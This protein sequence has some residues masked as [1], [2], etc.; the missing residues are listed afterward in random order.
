MKQKVKVIYIAGSGRTGS[1]LLSAL[2]AQHPSC[3]NIGQS[4]D[5]SIAL[6][7]SSQCTCGKNITK[8]EYWSLVLEMIESA[9]TK[10]NISREPKLFKKLCNSISTFRGRNKPGSLKEIISLHTSYID[11]LG[12]KYTACSEIANDAV[13]VDSSKSPELVVALSQIPEIELKVINLVRYPGAVAVSWH[14]RNNDWQHTMKMCKAW[15]KRQ[16]QLR[17]F[18]RFADIPVKRIL[19][20]DF[21]SNPKTVLSEIQKWA[22]LIPNPDIFTGKNTVNMKWD[23]Q[24][25]FPPANEKFLSEKP[26][27][28][29]IY[30][31][32]E[33][34]SVRYMIIRWMA[35][36]LTF[37]ENIRQGYLPK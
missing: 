20:E 36:V 12:C 6:R 11:Y 4:R 22:G 31:H 29:Q 3:F 32:R 28:L 10:I 7:E 17:D 33:W 23:N 35:Y 19:Y 34:M 14:K 27:S 16:E 30:D 25:L 13:L 8:C 26:V 18:T 37:P 9:S 21:V 2:I 15:K 24:H 5:V 1:T